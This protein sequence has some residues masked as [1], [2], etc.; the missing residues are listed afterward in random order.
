MFGLLRSLGNAVDSMLRAEERQPIVDLQH[1]WES[2]MKVLAVA[3]DEV[4]EA[5][6]ERVPAMGGAG[7]STALE[8]IRF[9]IEHMFSLLFEEAEGARVRTAAREG[10]EVE[11]TPPCMEFLLA[12]GRLESI[13]RCAVRNVPKGIRRTV[14]ANGDDAMKR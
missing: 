8:R 10:G 11:V 2:F 3:R 4:D 14:R 5:D 12:S 13:A 9:N 6:G 1:T 7:R